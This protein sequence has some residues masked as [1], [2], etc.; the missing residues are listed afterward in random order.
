MSWWPEA[1]PIAEKVESADAHNERCERG[2][3]N[4]QT[5]DEVSGIE[6]P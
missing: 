6:L 2:L 4:Q 5:L 1:K 3:S